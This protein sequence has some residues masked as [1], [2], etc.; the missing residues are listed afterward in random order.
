MNNT[1]SSESRCICCKKYGHTYESCDDPRLLLFMN[2]QVDEEVFEY[3]EGDNSCC[4]VFECELCNE[5]LVE[6]EDNEPIKLELRDCVHIF[7]KEC[8]QS[9][10]IKTLHSYNN[11]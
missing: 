10:I 9:L 3:D 5:Y 8:W 7:C 2:N 1:D 6:N 11:K 4:D